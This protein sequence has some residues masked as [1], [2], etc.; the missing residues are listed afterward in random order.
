MSGGVASMLNVDLVSLLVG[1]VL[2]ATG[3]ILVRVNLKDVRDGRPRTFHP[4][5]T[6]VTLLLA[7]AFLGMAVNERELRF[8]FD[9]IRR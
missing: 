2:L 9:Q 8:L 7:T 3:L 1:A 6:I 5:I 4:V